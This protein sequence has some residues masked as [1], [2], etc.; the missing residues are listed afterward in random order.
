[1]MP[2]AVATGE[3]DALRAGARRQV[4]V[5]LVAIAAAAT[6]LAVALDLRASYVAATLGAALLGAG[7]LLRYLPGRHPHARFGAANTV[8]LARAVPTLLIAGLALEPFAAGAAAFSTVAGT[9]VAVLDGVDGRLA[10]RDGLASTFGARFDMETDALLVLA[11]SA[12]AWR[13]D[14]AGAWVLLSGLA[15]YLFVAAGAALPW[16]RRPLPPSRRRQVVCVV[17]VIVLLVVVASLLPRPAGAALALAGLLALAGSFAADVAWLA[18]RSRDSP[19]MEV[20]RC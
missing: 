5:A 6:S 19:D 1:M 11:L 17:Q 3:Q 8:T 16:L 12:L 10:R 14:R 18:R 2:G 20:S 9:L 7:V 4:G 15:R 13:W